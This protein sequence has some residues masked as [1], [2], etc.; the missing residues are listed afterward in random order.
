MYKPYYSCSLVVI[1]DR[2]AF[3]AATIAWIFRE[4]CGNKPSVIF[5]ILYFMPKAM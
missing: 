3:F 1:M 5:L 4:V 2:Q